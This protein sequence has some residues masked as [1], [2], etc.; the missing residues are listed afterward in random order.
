M[1]FANASAFLCISILGAMNSMPKREDVDN[2]LQKYLKDYIWNVH[3]INKNSIQ[4][5]DY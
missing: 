2:F 1:M 3:Y 5:L 4:F